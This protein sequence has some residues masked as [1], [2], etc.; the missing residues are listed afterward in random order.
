MRF[1]ECFEYLEASKR[2]FC[3]PKAK[4]CATCVENTD[5]EELTQSKTSPKGLMSLREQQKASGTGLRLALILVSRCLP[6]VP[7]FFRLVVARDRSPAGNCFLSHILIQ[8][9]LSLS[10]YGTSSQSFCAPLPLALSPH[11]RPGLYHTT[12]FDSLILLRDYL[13]LLPRTHPGG[14]GVSERTRRL[15]PACRFQVT[16]RTQAEKENL[17]IFTISTRHSVFQDKPTETALL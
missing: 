4:L 14:E 3:L 7:L 5:E 8:S 11:V 1:F 9:K 12:Q 13:L 2:C 6:L 10:V 17:R 15:P 16:S